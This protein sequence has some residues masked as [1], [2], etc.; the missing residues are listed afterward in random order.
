MGQKK[1]WGNKAETIFGYMSEENVHDLKD[2]LTMTIYR[3]WRHQKKITDKWPSWGNIPIKS[4]NTKDENR[5]AQACRRKLVI[6][7]GANAS[8]LLSILESMIQWNKIHGDLRR[9][10][11]LYTQPTSY[12]CVKGEKGGGEKREKWSCRNGKGRGKGKKMQKQR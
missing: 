11:F 4:Q 10:V 7:Q 1:N 6:H 8:L 5:I 12:S 3:T 9:K 2:N